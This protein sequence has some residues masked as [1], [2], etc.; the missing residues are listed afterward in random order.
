M[1]GFLSIT[2]QTFFF[3]I[4]TKSQVLVG[5]Q[6][7]IFHSSLFQPVI[8]L[9]WCFCMFVHDK[10]VMVS[11]HVPCFFCLWVPSLPPTSSWC[12]RW[13]LERKKTSFV[14]AIVLL[15]CTLA[16][17]FAEDFFVE[18]LGCLICLPIGLRVW[19]GGH[20]R[21]NFLWEKLLNPSSKKPTSSIS[22][23]SRSA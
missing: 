2:V 17:S 14:Y 15:H 22:L 8:C 4:T 18:L 21:Q 3:N 7:T 11:K 6:L 16:T 9:V 1:S 13:F 20:T 5:H 23:T 12:H 19:Q 10:I